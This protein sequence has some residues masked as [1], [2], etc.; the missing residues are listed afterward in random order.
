MAICPKVS[1]VIPVYGKFDLSRALTTVRSVLT[2]KGVDYEVIVSEQGEEPRFPTMNGVRTIFKYHRPQED[3]SDFNPGNVRNRAIAL[4]KGEFIYTNDA[5]VV[6]LE[7]DYLTRAIKVAERTPTTALYRPF[8]R[9]LPQGQYEEFERRITSQGIEEAIASLDKSQDYVATVD[10]KPI[11]LRVFEKESVYPKTF[12]AFEED[13]Q[14][15]IKDPANQ[16]REPI[17]W[18]ENRHCGANLF[19]R[20]DFLEV[21]GYSEEFVNW[22]CEDS[23]LQWKLSEAYNLEFFP[24][25]LEVLHLDH[26]KCYFSSEMWKRN[27]A[28]S[29]RRVKEGLAKAIEIDRESKVWQR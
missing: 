10:C 21:G 24:A 15:Y 16:G 26:S 20:E 27:E 13:F 1:V 17:F 4:A 14:A 7:P 2:Q 9:R 8:M 23:D 18:N 3:L 11:K 12:T 5:D 6:F 19:R 22:G 29:E 25:N 28:I